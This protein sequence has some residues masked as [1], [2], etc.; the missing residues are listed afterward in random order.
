MIRGLAWDD[1]PA[2][3]NYIVRLRDALH[4]KGVELTIFNNEDQFIAKAL[5]GTWDFLITD[6][7]KSARSDATNEDD[8]AHGKQVGIE[9]LS[10]I[11]NS[12]IDCPVY[13]ITHAPEEAAA[14][15]KNFPRVLIRPKS[16]FPNWV[17][18]DIIRE[19]THLGRLL[20]R[21]KVFL[22][23]AIGCDAY[24]PIETWLQ[25]VGLIVEKVGPGNLKEH[26]SKGLVSK[27]STC[28][29]IVAVC[30]A[31]DRLAGEGAYQPRQNVLIEIGMS[32]ALF[33]GHERLII[34]RQRRGTNQDGFETQLPSDLAGILTIPFVETTGESLPVLEQALTS[35]GFVLGAKNKT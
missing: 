26:L 22:I 27:L 4:R 24:L 6:L 31:D 8:L 9:L 12:P 17:A 28:G 30:T 21:S 19:L 15:L 1:Q 33:R 14:H 20:N 18:D 29:A 34:L 11:N 2:G 10:A 3:E 23:Y 32:L 16:L 35:R 13:C 25:G 7:Y 5:D